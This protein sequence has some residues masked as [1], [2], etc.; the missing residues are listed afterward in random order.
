MWISS[1]VWAR[2]ASQ[3]TFLQSEASFPPHRKSWHSTSV[4]WSI[5][6]QSQFKTALWMQKVH[7]LCWPPPCGEWEGFTSD[8]TSIPLAHWQSQSKD[9]EGHLKNVEDAFLTL[10]WWKRTLSK[11]KANLIILDLSLCPRT[12]TVVHPNDYQDENMRPSNVF[13][14]PRWGEWKHSAIMPGFR[15]NETD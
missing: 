5:L 6:W 15:S 9:S 2:R 11:D 8:I 3:N 13:M 14:E 12:V 7:F 10:L 4:P 1:P